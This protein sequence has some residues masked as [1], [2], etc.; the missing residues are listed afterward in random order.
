MLITSQ[1]YIDSFISQIWP[2][3]NQTSNMIAG[4]LKINM[5]F[6][7]S[8]L[9]SILDITED[10]ILGQIQSIKKEQNLSEE[11]LK[12]PKKNRMIN[13]YRG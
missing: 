2:F 4:F 1:E 7:K 12:I 3:E 10:L 5:N 6:S 8:A 13:K 9:L 11:Q